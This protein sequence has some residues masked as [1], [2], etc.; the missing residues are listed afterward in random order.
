MWWGGTKEVHTTGV[1]GD[2]S[3]S[4]ELCL[5]IMRQWVIENNYNPLNE[6]DDYDL[7]RFCRARNF[8]I[9]NV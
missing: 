3:S 9:A 5:N 4:Q 8:V 7:L 2:L 6:W 1:V